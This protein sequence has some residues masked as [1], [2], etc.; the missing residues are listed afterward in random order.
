[1]LATAESFTGGMVARRLTSVPGSSDAFVGAVVAYAD[2]V[3]AR[4]LGVPAEILDPA[5]R[6]SAE[7]AAAMAAARA[8]GSV[9]TSPSRSRGS[10]AR[11]AEGRR[12]LSASSISTQRALGRAPRR[13]RLPR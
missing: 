10:P 11:V 3:K 5:R 8:S 12:S 6:C 13:L 2:E 1:M 7:T 9:Q 4:E